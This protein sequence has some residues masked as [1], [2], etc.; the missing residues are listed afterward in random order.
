MLYIKQTYLYSVWPKFFMNYY[1]LQ[2]VA[3]D[4]LNKII[5][6][7]DSD[8]FLLLDHL[9]LAIQ[10]RYGLGYKFVLEKIRKMH[11]CGYIDFNEV[12]GEVKNTNVKRVE[13]P[14]DENKEDIY[15]YQM[16]EAD[17]ISNQPP[18]PIQEVEAESTG[19]S[20]TEPEDRILSDDEVQDQIFKLTESEFKE[21][22]T[23]TI[24]EQIPPP[25]PEDRLADLKSTV[26]KIQ[27]K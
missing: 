23:A 14:D 13:V 10:N 7:A 8:S 16:D 1:E 15:T 4:M 18:E 22:E 5:D 24:E 19:E 11:N 20:E 26:N 9:Q 21:E 25:P 2:K 27:T 12:T 17:H 6:N 3:S